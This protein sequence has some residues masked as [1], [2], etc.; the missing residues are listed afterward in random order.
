MGSSE[1]LRPSKNTYLNPDKRL[2]LNT[3]ILPPITTSDDNQI[4]ILHKVLVWAYH[5]LSDTLN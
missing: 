3:I 5:F 2:P 1:Q 4:K